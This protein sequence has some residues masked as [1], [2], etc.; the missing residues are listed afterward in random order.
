VSR[1]K[2]RLRGKRSKLTAA[3]ARHLLGLTDTGNYN[4]AEIAELFRVS[5][6]TIYRTVHRVR[7]VLP[8]PN[9][10]SRTLCRNHADSPLEQ[11][12]T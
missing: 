3:Q 10:N 1:A 4:M 11:T 8:D 2:G 7:P 5:R 6:S 12:A 9:G